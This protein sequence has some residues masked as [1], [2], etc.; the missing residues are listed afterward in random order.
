MEAQLR[1]RG[2]RTLCEGVLELL[3]DVAETR[4]AAF[5]R[6]LTLAQGQDHSAFANAVRPALGLS[7]ADGF[8]A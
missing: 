1:L 3:G 6:F 7:R 8:Q 4:R 5:D 2:R